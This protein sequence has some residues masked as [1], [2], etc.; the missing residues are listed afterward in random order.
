MGGIHF[1]PFV[2]SP[3]LLKARANGPTPGEWDVRVLA[4]PHEQ[5]LGPEFIHARETVIRFPGA[6]RPG[7]DISRIETRR[8]G[9]GWIEGG[10]ISQVS[11]E[12]YSHRGEPSGA[13]GIARKGGET[14]LSVGVESGDGF[15]RLER[16]A[17][18]GSRLVI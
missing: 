6:E 10:A 14:K 18:I 5:G 16:V 2:S 13:R 3:H 1:V 4:A 8:R 12:A 17:A 7:M 9:D 11:A 15:G